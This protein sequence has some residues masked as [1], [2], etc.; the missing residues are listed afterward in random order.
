LCVVVLW[1]W[2]NDELRTIQTTITQAAVI[3]G[4]MVMSAQLRR[5]CW[6]RRVWWNE[7]HPMDITKHSAVVVVELIG[8]TAQFRR[9][10]WDRRVWWN[11]RHTK[12]TTKHSVYCC[13]L[14][15]EVRKSPEST[16]RAAYMTTDKATGRWCYENEHEDVEEHH[17][18]VP[19]LNRG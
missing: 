10:C 9:A 16:L 1:V 19:R 4:L 2:W 8:K 5:A 6:E 13:Q 17:K 14:D 7:R 12:E 3:V 11:E 15:G 18:N